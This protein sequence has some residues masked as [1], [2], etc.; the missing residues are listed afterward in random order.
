MLALASTMFVIIRTKA[1]LSPIISRS[2]Q[3]I[4]EAGFAAEAGRESSL[5]DLMHSEMLL[6]DELTQANVIKHL[7][8]NH[9]DGEVLHV[10]R[11]VFL[12][13]C[14]RLKLY[15]FLHKYNVA[16]AGCVNIVQDEAQA[17]GR[18]E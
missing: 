5:P 10:S 4:D 8:V 1:I 3:S 18:P 6:N 2:Q 14:C 11:S 16:H 12:M 13:C 17:E 7:I 9:K 15:L